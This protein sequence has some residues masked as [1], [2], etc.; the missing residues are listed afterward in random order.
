MCRRTR[1]RYAISKS[2][3]L[4]RCQLLFFKPRLPAQEMGITD[5]PG[6]T[7]QDISAMSAGVVAGAGRK[8]PFV[9]SFKVRSMWRHEIRREGGL[10][11]NRKRAVGTRVTLGGTDEIGDGSMAHSRET[12]RKSAV[13]S[14]TSMRQDPLRLFCRPCPPSPSFQA[15]SPSPP[16]SLPGHSGLACPW[17]ILGKGCLPR[18]RAR[19][20]GLIGSTPSSTSSVPWSR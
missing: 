6:K 12:R 11:R 18:P 13:L 10:P 7:R 20:C 1:F 15:G 3:G 4:G 16:P 17:S 5:S 2:G 19:A 14:A 9:S 8:W